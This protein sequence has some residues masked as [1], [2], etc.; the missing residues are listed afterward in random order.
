MV[1]EKLEKIK[2]FLSQGLK[3]NPLFYF[4]IVILVFFLALTAIWHFAKIPEIKEIPLPKPSPEEIIKR[5]QEKAIKE[6]LQFLNEAPVLSEKEIEK[7]LQ[8]LNKGR[9]LLEEEI[10]KQLEELGR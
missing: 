4:G 10:K 3:K 8:Q 5:Q 1:L 9:P 7:Q 6:Q 2:I